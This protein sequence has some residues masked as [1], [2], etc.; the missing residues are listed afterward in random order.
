MAEKQT[1]VQNGTVAALN[2]V[3]GASASAAAAGG[4]EESTSL[5]KLNT[6]NKAN[7]YIPFDNLEVGVPYKIHRFGS[8]ND[9]RFSTKK[10]KNQVRLAAF[11]D[12]GY[13]ILPERFDRL[14]A[15]VENLNAEKMYIIFNG[16]GENNRFLN[17]E[18]IEM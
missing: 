4:E 12:D 15:E 3:D 16:R 5:T 10:K 6:C 17:I 11:I 1:V 18:F 14:V 2:A 8:Y 9:D 13:L 7:S